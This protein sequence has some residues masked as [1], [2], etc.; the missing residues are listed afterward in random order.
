VAP[1]TDERDLP[2]RIVHPST[3]NQTRLSTL[4]PDA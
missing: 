1:G 3:T 4:E 2:M